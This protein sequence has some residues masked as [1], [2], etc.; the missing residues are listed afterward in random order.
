LPDVTGTQLYSTGKVKNNKIG[1][2]EYLCPVLYSTAKMIDKAQAAALKDGYCLKIYDSYRPRSVSKK[3][4]SNLQILYDSNK[5][6]K[7]NIDTSTGA[8]GRK[9]TWGQGWFLAQSLSA[10]NTGAAID[11]SLCK[12]SDKTE[13][14][15]PTAMHE[16]S[17]KAIKYY[18]PSVSKKSA[19]Y[20]KEMTEDAK[21]LDKYM[22]DAGMTT[23]ASEWWHFQD[24]SGY[25]RIKKATNGNGCDFQVLSKTCDVNGD[26]KVDVTD[27]SLILKAYS[28][29]SVGNGE[30]DSKYDVNGDG[31]VDVTDA[32]IVLKYYALTRS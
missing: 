15:M 1:R 29:A 4:V 18:S 20:S 11:V 3:I 32:S 6:V 16:L 8:S 9:Y 5:T 13:C 2:D 31:K 7:A 24:Q 21:R 10:H 22:T 14:K 23:L 12:N 25:T 17:T 30:A 26:G 28:N 19:N 27:A